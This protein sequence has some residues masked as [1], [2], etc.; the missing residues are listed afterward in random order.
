MSARAAD[1]IFNRFCP[2]HTAP[3]GSPARGE[4]SGQ[5][6]ERPVQV[7]ISYQ[8]EVDIHDLPFIP[9]QAGAT[10]S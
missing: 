10:E 5:G 4:G 8:I 9:S 7:H 3:M 2:P 6:T 1:V